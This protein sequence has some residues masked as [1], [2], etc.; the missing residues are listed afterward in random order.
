MTNE[1]RRRAMREIREQAAE[2]AT[3]HSIP[4]DVAELAL[5]YQGLDD[6]QELLQQLA[7]DDLVGFIAFGDDDQWVDKR[8]HPN[9][10]Q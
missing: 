10:R 3:A 9:T 4:D 2:A 5:L 6:E 8:L 7:H 1:E